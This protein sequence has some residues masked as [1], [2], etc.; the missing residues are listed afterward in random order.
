[1]DLENGL[2]RIAEAG[3]NLRRSLPRQSVNSEAPNLLERPAALRQH[4]LNVG[5]AAQE[6]A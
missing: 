5:N 1:M 3:A 2:G 6:T 4:R